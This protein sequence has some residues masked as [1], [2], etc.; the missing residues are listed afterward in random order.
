MEYALVGCTVNLVA[1]VQSLT[2]VHKVDILVTDA[3]RQQL[4]PRFVLVPMPAEM[5]KGIDDPVVTYAVQG[6]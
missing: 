3:L 6:M 1:R 5:V 4:D 2:R